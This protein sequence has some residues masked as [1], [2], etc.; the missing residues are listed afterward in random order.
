MR[1][2]A[3]PPVLRTRAVFADLYL[4][5]D[6]VWYKG[7]EHPLAGVRAAVETGGDI[8]RRIT[9]TRLVLTG[10]FALALRK[11]KDHRDMFLIVEG[12][13]FSWLVEA[14]P[15]KLIQARKFANQINDAAARAAQ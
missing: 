8:E 4:L 9:A 12:P 11:K 10:V 5:K 15:K 1:L 2:F 7:E 13:G 14:S 6:G 3:M